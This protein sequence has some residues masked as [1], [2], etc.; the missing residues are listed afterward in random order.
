AMLSLSAIGAVFIPHEWMNR[1][2]ERMGLGP[3]PDLPMIGY[4]ARS[5]SLFYA[6]LGAIALYVSFDPDRHLGLIRQFALTGLAVG[7]I[8]TGI[9]LL[10]PVPLWWTASEGAFLFAYFGG[11]FWL[12]RTKIAFPHSQTVQS[13]QQ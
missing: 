1:I 10:A 4:L 9:D 2:H 3:L 12:S 6:W 13:R 11:L 5:L 7:V 8:Q